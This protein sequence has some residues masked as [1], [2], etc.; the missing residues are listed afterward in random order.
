MSL[1]LSGTVNI[2]RLLINPSVCLPHHTVSTF[3]HLPVPLSQAF[4][5]N[6]HE[7]VD[8]RAVIL[9]KD[10]CFAVPKQDEIH[11]PYRVSCFSNCLA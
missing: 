4:T 7:K 8:I 2:L 3:N 10:N 1:N 6:G 11:E 9:D 5:N